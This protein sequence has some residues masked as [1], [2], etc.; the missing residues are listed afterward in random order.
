MKMNT[1]KDKNIYEIF[2]ELFCFR[3][4]KRR[5]NIKNLNKVYD[6]VER[7]GKNMKIIQC[8]CAFLL[9]G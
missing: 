8:F 7:P 6:L 2:T 9:N 4:L 1:I 3:T 5:E